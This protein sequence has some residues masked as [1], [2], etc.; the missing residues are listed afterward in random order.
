MSLKKVFMD[1]QE[2][3]L[4]M[5]RENLPKELCYHSYEHTLDVVTA[6]EKIAIAENATEEEIFLLR[7]A[8]VFHDTGYIFSRENHEQKSCEIATE[9]LSSKGI[10]ENYIKI[11]CELIL[12]TKVPQQPKDKLERI[13]CDADLDYLGRDDYFTISEN[14]FREFKLFG[15][16]S[17]EN[18]W[19]KMQVKFFESHKYFTETSNKTRNRKKEENLNLIRGNHNAD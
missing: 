11:I 7:T 6:T 5:L 1:A 2:H 4:K 12:A 3:A 10:P 19:K 18:D 16:V 13:I 8:A 14:V 9:V 17:D 15:I